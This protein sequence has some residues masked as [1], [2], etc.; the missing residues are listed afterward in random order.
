MVYLKSI[1]PFI[2][3]IGLIG[4]ISGPYEIKTAPLSPNE[5][6]LGKAEGS[7]GGVLLFGFI[8]IGQNARFKNAYN[9]A[10]QTQPGSTRLIDPT[11]EEQWFYGFI[12]EGFIFQ[13]KGTAVGPN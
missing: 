6:I 9:Q 2:I 10:L 3:L 7:S 8:P 12:L 1:L 11:I 5:K 4:C 13:I